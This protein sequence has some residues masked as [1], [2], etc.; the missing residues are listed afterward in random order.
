MTNSALEIAKS[1]KKSNAAAIAQEKKLEK[2]KKAQADK[3]IAIFEKTID[4]VLSEFD[5]VTGIEY[6]RDTGTLHKKGKKVAS[7]KVAFSTW[8]K[9]GYEYKVPEL[10]WVIVWQVGEKEEQV[11]ELESEFVQSFGSA[12][13]FII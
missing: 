9:R 8:D 10:G 3:L 7:A 4:T 1:V 13:A 12:M 11:S 5:G 2:A 6:D